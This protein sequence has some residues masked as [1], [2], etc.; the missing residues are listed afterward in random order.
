MCFIVRRTNVTI[1]VAAFALSAVPLYGQD[2]WRPLFNGKDLDGWHACNGTAPFTV[3]DGA[4][5]GKTVTGSPNSF[6]CAKETFGDLILEYE[7]KVESE[8]NSG[9]MVRGIADPAIKN[10]RM[11][12]YQV[13]IDP[14][15]RA[16]S[17]GIYDEA[18]KG[19]LHTLEGQE[20]SKKALRKGDWNRFRVE[21]IGTS[22]RTWLN[23]VE[24]ANILDDTT[25]RGLIALQV[26]S[27]GDD[28]SRVGEAIR[29]RN[30]RVMTSNLE[31][32]RT[33][34]RGVVPQFNHVPN[35]VTEREA[36]DGWKLL[37]DGRTTAGWRG[38]RLDRFPTSGWKIEGGVLSVLAAEGGESAAGGDIVTTGQ[39]GDFELIV[40]FK[41][42]KGANSGVKYFVDTGL[43]KGEG[44]AIGCEYQI[45]DDANHPDA[46]AGMN[47]NRKL[48]GL[49]DL[50]PP[51]NIRFNGIDEWNRARIVSRGRHVEHWLNGFKTV[52]YER[53][54]P[55]W[56]ALVAKSKYAVWPNF[57]ERE[58]GHILLQDHG[59]LVSFRTVKIREM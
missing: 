1:M 4:I 16:W 46:K 15:D 9:V 17:A 40:E 34:D 22:I 23:G 36:R 58:K 39:Y 8:M 24:C 3:E 28:K 51:R 42:T 7:A 10:G 14:S 56:R 33:P 59:N 57:G 5:V 53:G 30:I 35:T 41:I 37:W 19:W 27:I 50:I 2:G 20:E 47:G 11:H 21:A 48:A 13:E 43:N 49:Y 54:T 44:S 25:A 18:R 31:R 45:L 55:E 38:A 52:E 32:N 12:G 6:L 26:H 29:F